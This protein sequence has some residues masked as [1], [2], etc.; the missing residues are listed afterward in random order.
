MAQDTRKPV[1]SL[2]MMGHFLGNDFKLIRRDSF[3]ITMAL[4]AIVIAVS[5]RFLLPWADTY[6]AEAQILPSTTGDLRLSDLYPMLVSFIGLLQSTILVGGIF[7]F[8]FLDEKDGRTLQAIMVTPMPMQKFMFYRV[9]LP[10]AL[11]LPTAVAMILIIDQ[12]SVP[13]LQLLALSAG[14]ALFT[15]LIILFF[16]ITADNKVQGF[17]MAKFVAISGWIVIAAWFIPEPMQWIC[18]LF[19]PYLTHKAFWM[20]HAGDALWWVPLLVGMIY[21]VLLAMLMERYFRTRT[22]VG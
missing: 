17:A 8:V 20:A 9:A 19:P 10:A 15:P 18:A 5:V 14:A 16:A 13:I 6:L 12:A 1:L 22:R 11:T 21:Q 7:G 2:A 4:M 3:L